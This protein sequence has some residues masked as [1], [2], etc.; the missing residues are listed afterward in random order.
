MFQKSN[1]FLMEKI[2]SHTT[3][4]FSFKKLFLLELL[5]TKKNLKGIVHQKMMQKTSK[6][7]SRML[8]KH[9]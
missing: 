1:K 4:I 3:F 6:D 5:L 2:K 9:F 8:H 7:C